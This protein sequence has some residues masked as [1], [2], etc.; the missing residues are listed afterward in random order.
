MKLNFSIK[1]YIAVLGVAGLL[2][3]ACSKQTEH[4]QTIER[5]QEVATDSLQKTGFMECIIK[6][7]DKE[8]MIIDTMQLIKN[9]DNDYSAKQYQKKESLNT[10]SIVLD[11]FT[12]INSEKDSTRIQ[13]DNNTEIVFQT[14]SFDSTGNFKFN[15]KLSY[16]TFVNLISSKDFDRFRTIPFK[17][18]IK[19]GTALLIEEIYIP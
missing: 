12:I 1:F 4:V 17:F 2:F 11:G 8:F 16:G 6:D 9:T 14:F 3:S 10:H 5:K 7:G 18:I 15:E 19:N 13:I